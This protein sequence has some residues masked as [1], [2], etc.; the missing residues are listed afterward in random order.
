[1]KKTHYIDIMEKVLSAYTGEH[2]DRYYQDVKEKGLTEHGFPRLT[3]NIGI[4]IA[5][6]RRTDL[7][8]RFIQMMNLCCEEI[9]QVK[10]AANEFS[11][12]EIIFC[13]L[14]L[15]K[16][17]VVSTEQIN[18]WKECLAKV[19]VQNCYSIHSLSIVN[20]AQLFTLLSGASA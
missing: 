1:M 11:I 8:S 19:T 6:G 5:H 20:A 4:L 14:E 2:I 9:P 18:A 16:C 7:L 10:D 3:A 15:E 13:I 17:S 12:K